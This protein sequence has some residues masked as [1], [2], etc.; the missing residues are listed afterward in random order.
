MSRGD[1]SV[2][3]ETVG[4]LLNR[5]H[6]EK[7]EQAG[8]AA[9]VF[10]EREFRKMIPP[11]V[12]RTWPEDLVEDALQSFLVKIIETPLPGGIDNLPG[13]LN[14]SFRRHCIDRHRARRRRKESS[15]GSIDPSWEP[16]SDPRNSPGTAL[17]RKERAEHV[18][19]C[20]GQLAIE[21]RIVLKLVHAPEWLDEQELGWIS[22]KTG[23]KSSEVLQAIT[24]AQDIHDLTRIFDPGDDDPDDQKLRRKRMERFRKRRSRAREKL[25][26]LLKGGL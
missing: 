18:Q 19:Y 13:Y 8:R 24:A 25:R 11:L 2:T 16:H 17:A 7:D 12:R 20:I 1:K 15:V 10:M 5:W 26:V 3:W 23:T 14:T 21:D 22:D 6:T 4:T 9:L